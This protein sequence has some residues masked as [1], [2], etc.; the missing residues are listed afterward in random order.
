MDCVKLVTKV[1]MCPG[2]NK[3]ISISFFLICWSKAI[4]ESLKVAYRALTLSSVLVYK[5]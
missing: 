3:N 5:I 1:V 4:G 2:E